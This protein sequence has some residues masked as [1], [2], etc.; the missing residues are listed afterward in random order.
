MMTS[1]LEITKG[2]R[3]DAN[4]LEV[5][6]HS[7]DTTKVPNVGIACPLGSVFNPHD[8]RAS[9]TLFAKV[10]TSSIVDASSPYITISETIAIFAT[11]I[12]KFRTEKPSFGSTSRNVQP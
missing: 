8:F 3:A 10:C 6:I 1:M 12:W 2:L 4:A 11:C 9:A 5:H 7:L